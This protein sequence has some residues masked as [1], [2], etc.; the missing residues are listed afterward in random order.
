MAGGDARQSCD[1]RISR[2]VR[3]HGIRSFKMYTC[4]KGDEGQRIGI[5]GE[6]DG[7]SDLRADIAAALAKANVAVRELRRDRASLESLFVAATAREASAA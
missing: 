5:R 7:A 1:E 4:Y 2:W 3:E 6:S